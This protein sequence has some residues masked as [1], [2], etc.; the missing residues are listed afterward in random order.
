MFEERTGSLSNLIPDW[1]TYAA[2][3]LVVC[4]IIFGLILYGRKWIQRQKEIQLQKRQADQRQAFN[5]LA[6][7]FRTALTLILLPS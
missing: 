6:L 2:V 1:W 3:G 4:G 5:E 7:E